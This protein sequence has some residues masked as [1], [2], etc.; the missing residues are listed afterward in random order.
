M[1]WNHGFIQAISSEMAFFV[2][3]KQQGITTS[4]KRS[5]NL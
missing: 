5:P 1:T 4:W 3:A 2:H